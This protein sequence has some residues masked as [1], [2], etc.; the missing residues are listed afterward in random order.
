MDF[1]L[2]KEAL[3]AALCP[4]GL[5]DVEEKRETKKLVHFLEEQ[6]QVGP[7]A[8]RPG[9]SQWGPPYPPYPPCQGGKG[10]R[11]AGGGGGGK[12]VPAGAGVI[13]QRNYFSIGGG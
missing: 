2:L 4:A 1:P 11:G 3:C 6:E 9:W 5:W 8:R 10:G 7:L 13:N 12:G